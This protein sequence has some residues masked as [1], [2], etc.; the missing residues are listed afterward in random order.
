MQ[1][2]WSAEAVGVTIND[3]SAVANVV[4]RDHKNALYEKMPR[5]FRDGLE[6]SG[7]VMQSVTFEDSDENCVLTFAAIKNKAIY[8][9]LI[10]F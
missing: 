6:Q 8:T 10:R 2:F 4:D 5:D 1:Y 7:I 3:E 9:I